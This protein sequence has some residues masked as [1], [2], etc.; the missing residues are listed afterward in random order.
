MRFGEQT[1]EL[2]KG[3][4]EP[5]EHFTRESGAKDRFGNQY[6]SSKEFSYLDSSGKETN[7]G[8][9]VSLE[10][11]KFIA[12]HPRILHDVGGGLAFFAN[13]FCNI[14]NHTIDLGNG[15]SLQFVM[16]G[17]QSQF[18][19]LKVNE[20]KYAIKI[21]LTEITE[22]NRKIDQPYIN[23]M[24]QTQAVATDLK[25]DLE[26]ISVKMSSFLFASGQVSCTEYEEEE[27]NRP[28]LTYEFLDRLHFIVG[29]Y[30]NKKQQKEGD[31]LWDNIKLDFNGNIE[32]MARNFITKKDGAVWIDPFRY[33]V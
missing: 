2:R 24:L 9:L 21:H 23:E 14:P 19:I 33:Q 17:G 7:A 18:Y 11:Q 1:G 26:K 4:G 25:S 28:M 5:L 22:G 30:L 6:L 31:P 16:S 3:K 12:E 15:R 20:K 8:I 13:Y 32:E 29:K 27:G 10:G